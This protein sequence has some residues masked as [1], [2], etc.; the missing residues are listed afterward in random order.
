MDGLQ[1]LEQFPQNR[2]IYNMSCKKRSTFRQS[3]TVFIDIRIDNLR[4]GLK[5]EWQMN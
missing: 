4:T 3:E 5:G 2:N 1:R